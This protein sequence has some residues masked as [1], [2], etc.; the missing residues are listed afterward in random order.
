MGF[1]KRIAIVLV[2]A[3][4]VAQVQAEGGSAFQAEMDEFK[5][6]ME[7]GHYTKIKNAYDDL[8]WSGISSPEVYDPLEKLVLDSYK[9]A[10]SGKDAEKLSWLVKGLALSGNAK[11]MDTLNLVLAN[12][13]SG[14]VKKHTNKAID[15][16]PKYKVWNE[17][18]AKGIAQ[19]SEDGLNELRIGNMLSSGDYYLIR[20]AAK[21]IHFEYFDNSK[22]VNQAADTLRTIYPDASESIEVDAAA[23]LCKALGASEDESQQALL[24]EVAKKAKSGKVR[25]HAKKNLS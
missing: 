9:G 15:R 1:V 24:Q 13:S 2:S 23:W 10:D 8:Q 7:S 12:S 22:L 16:L 19:A 18:I 11:Y 17:V 20:A 6:V 5:K 25:K 3:L 14:K 21:R 4:F